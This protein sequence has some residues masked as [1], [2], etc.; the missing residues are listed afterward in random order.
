MMKGLILVV[1]L[2][3]ITGIVKADF[4]EVDKLYIETEKMTST[5]RGYYL[6]KNSEPKYN[7]N[8]GLNM[9]D[10]LGILYSDNK[11]SST[12]DQ[13]QFRYISL[14]TEFGLNTTIGLQIYYRHYSGHM[15][16]AYEQGSE[17]FPQE[18]VIG[19]RFNILK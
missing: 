17:R 5:N 10:G 9:T 19:I 13:S 15:L 18:N 11:I 3:F 16:D 2:L 1:F 12:T 4:V 8:L 6:P 14:D 7:F